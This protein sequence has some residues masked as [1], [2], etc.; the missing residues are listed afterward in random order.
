MRV[1]LRVG[2]EWHK[3]LYCS[4][5]IE[6]YRASRWEGFKASLC[7]CDCLRDL[8][9]QT[10]RG[11]PTHLR[12]GDLMGTASKD[13]IEELSDGTAPELPGVDLST[14]RI[15]A[16]MEALR[17]LGENEEEITTEDIGGIYKTFWP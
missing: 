10:E 14:E 11:F 12:V 3:S 17:K 8:R 7:N 1:N 4:E 15:N 6:I 5:C 9:G 16:L 2:T 13:I